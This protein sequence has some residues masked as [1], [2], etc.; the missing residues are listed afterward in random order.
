MRMSKSLH[1]LAAYQRAIELVVDVYEVTKSFPRDERFGLTAQ[2]RRAAV[3][4]PSQIAEGHGRLHYSEWRQF[5]SQARGSLF[6]VETQMIIAKRLDY[7]EEAAYEWIDQSIRRTGKALVGL[8]R[9]VLQRERATQPRNR[10][11]PQPH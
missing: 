9:W 6:E 7:V 2:I 5:L 10:A 4:V 1:D 11:T 3:G 8:I